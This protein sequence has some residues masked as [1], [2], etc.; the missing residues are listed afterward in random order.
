MHNGSF[1][2]FF[3]LKDALHPQSTFLLYKKEK[4]A[5]NVFVPA[6]RIKHKGSS[7]GLRPY[8]IPKGA[9]LAD[10]YVSETT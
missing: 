3:S 1:F 9:S 10:R 7:T 4:E 2:L 8:I 5:K 6:H